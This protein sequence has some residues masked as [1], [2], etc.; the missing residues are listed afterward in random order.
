[1][2][3][4]PR[5][6]KEGCVMEHRLIAEKKIGRYL[7]KNE[8]VHHINGNKSDNRPENLETLSRKEHAR[9]HFD[10]V[11]EVDRLKKIISKCVSCKSL[12]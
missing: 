8:D 4:H 7:E 3:N 9:Q 11:K 12:L 1:M 6:N 5:A 10:A 2:P